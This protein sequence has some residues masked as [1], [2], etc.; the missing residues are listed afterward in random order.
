MS[1]FILLREFIAG[2]SEEALIWG[3][4]DKRAITD[5]E[6]ELEIKLPESVCDFIQEFGNINLYP[7]RVLIAGNEEGNFSCVTETRR[8]RRRHP[9]VPHNYVT[10]MSYAEIVYCVV[11]GDV[12]T[13]RVISWDEHYPPME[14]SIIREF[15][16]FYDFIEWLIVQSRDIASD[17]RFEF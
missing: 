13:S 17:T 16:S 6:A 12:K 9:S 1:A 3:R 11:A 15:E 5:I 4:R 14:G 2:F 10:V 7:F 8:L